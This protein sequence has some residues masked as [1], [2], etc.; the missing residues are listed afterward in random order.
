MIGPDQLESVF[1]LKIPSSFVTSM[2]SIKY[3]YEK[4][5][6]TLLSLKVSITQTK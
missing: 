1:F 5:S 6:Y 4:V 2:S 3:I